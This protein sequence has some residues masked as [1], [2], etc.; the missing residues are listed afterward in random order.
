MPTAYMVF[1]RPVNPDTATSLIHGART[2]LGETVPVIPA[3]IQQ[4]LQQSMAAGQLVLPAFTPVWDTLKI[5]IASGGGDVVSAFGIYNELKAMP[6]TIHTHN[7]GAVDSAAIIPFMLGERRTAAASSAFFFHQI[8][9][10]FSANGNLTTTTI[11]DATEWLG[12]YEDLMADLVV[13][14]SGMEKSEVLKLM[15]EGTSIRPQ[16]ALELGLIHEIEEHSIPQNARSWQ[17]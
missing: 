3:Q 16:R 6:L 14:R 10:T 2:L 5:S 15:R 11:N 4:I 1:G 17:V 12:T 13:E 9:W 8:H 7:A